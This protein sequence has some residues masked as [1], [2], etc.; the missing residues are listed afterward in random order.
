MGKQVGSLDGHDANESFIMMYGCIMWRAT[1][2]WM[3]ID[4]NTTNN[5]S[6]FVIQFHS[7]KMEMV[8]DKSIL[9]KT[10]FPQ[11]KKN[12]N[13]QSRSQRYANLR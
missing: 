10:C 3:K 2:E 7:M 12:N 9:H 1:K 11:N 8:K 4:A 13:G 6:S 5:T